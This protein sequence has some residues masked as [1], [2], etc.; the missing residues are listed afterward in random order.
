MRSGRKRRVGTSS[1]GRRSRAISAFGRV[2]L[3]GRHLLEIL[4]LQ[5]LAVGEG[6]HGVDRVSSVSSAGRRALAAWRLP[7][8]RLGQRGG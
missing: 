8:Q 7:L 3:V 2:D 1:I 4:G 5:D 6:Q